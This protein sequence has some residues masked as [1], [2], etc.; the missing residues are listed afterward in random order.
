MW[1]MDDKYNR[2]SERKSFAKTS[3]GKH[4]LSLAKKSMEKNESVSGQDTWWTK[5]KRREGK[6]HMAD[7]RPS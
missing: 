1:G 5:V 7:G 4:D 2:G 6:I 3:W